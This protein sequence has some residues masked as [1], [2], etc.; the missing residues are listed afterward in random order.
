MDNDKFVLAFAH[1][2]RPLKVTMCKTSTRG[3]S[4]VLAADHNQI[5]PTNHFNDQTS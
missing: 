3:K 5:H 2:P 1:V 4:T